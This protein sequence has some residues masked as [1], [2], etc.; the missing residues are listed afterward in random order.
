MLFALSFGLIQKLS[1][2]SIVKIVYVWMRRQ[3][4]FSGYF[5]GFCHQNTRLRHI[6]KTHYY[7]KYMEQTIH[8]IDCCTLYF[9]TEEQKIHPVVTVSMLK[10]DI[11][12]L[13]GL[14]KGPLPYWSYVAHT[15]NW[16]FCWFFQKPNFLGKTINI[17]LNLVHIFPR[18]GNS[19]AYQND[20]LWV[21]WLKITG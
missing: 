21:V 11:L 3:V 12:V 19:N 14:V 9:V 16:G 5:L 7:S 15:M 2:I 6:I 20:I 1:E 10:N 17:H 4:W 18:N 8:L 13:W